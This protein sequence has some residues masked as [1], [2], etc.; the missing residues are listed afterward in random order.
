M[1]GLMDKLFGTQK[2]ASE[3]AKEEIIAPVVPGKLWTHRYFFHKELMMKGFIEKDEIGDGRYRVLDEY[4]NGIVRTTE[5]EYNFRPWLE[6]LLSAGLPSEP[7]LDVFEAGS[8][9]M[10]HCKGYPGHAIPDFSASDQE[11]ADRIRW[12][13]ENSSVNPDPE[14]YNKSKPWIKE[15]L[16]YLRTPRFPAVSRPLMTPELHKEDVGIHV[17]DFAHT[18]LPYRG[19]WDFDP[20][21]WKTAAKRIGEKKFSRLDSPVFFGARTTENVPEK[22]FDDTASLS[23]DSIA[24]AVD[25]IGWDGYRESVSGAWFLGRYNSMATH[26]N[27][28]IGDQGNPDTV[29]KPALEMKDIVPGKRPS[30]PAMYFQRI[31]D[32]RD[33]VSGGRIDVARD[34]HH[35][36]KHCGE[37]DMHFYG[38]KFRYELEHMPLDRFGFLGPVAHKP[39]LFHDWL[40]GNKESEVFA[41]VR[42]I[43]FRI[44]GDYVRNVITLGD[45]LGNRDHRLAYKGTTMFRKDMMNIPLSCVKGLTWELDQ[46]QI[47][48]RIVRLHLSICYEN[49]EV[50]KRQFSI[51]IDKWRDTWL[52]DA[53][54]YAVKHHGMSMGIDPWDMEHFFRLC[55]YGVEDRHGS[56][57]SAKI[58]RDIL[59]GLLMEPDPENAVRMRFHKETRFS[60]F[61]L[62]EKTGYRHLRQEFLRRKQAAEGRAMGHQWE[63]RWEIPLHE[64]RAKYKDLFPTIHEDPKHNYSLMEHYFKNAFSGPLT[65]RPGEF[66]TREYY[67]KS[68]YPEQSTRLF[69]P[70]PGHHNVDEK[71]NTDG[72]NNTLVQ[73]NPTP[74]SLIKDYWRSDERDKYDAKEPRQFLAEGFIRNG[75]ELD[76]RVSIQEY[77]D[78]KL[79][80]LSLPPIYGL[81]SIKALRESPSLRSVSEDEVLKP[82]IMERMND[83]YGEKDRPE[84]CIADLSDLSDLTR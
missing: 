34:M 57:N 16:D 75:E 9:S 70:L 61:L 48:R 47:D 83:S 80:K 2:K 13:L 22:F 66:F 60:V 84:D 32:S 12:L 3:Q 14:E 63:H 43:V 62:A 15:F 55:R 64:V 19:Q 65:L 79:N 28:G 18:Y 46:V 7:E 39:W 74:W 56:T 72:Y 10:K 41:E 37:M 1:F 59:Y 11:M 31:Y 17:V 67:Y 68:K 6:S 26:I 76:N 42:R 21:F 53:I 58:H 29:W 45:L 54:E 77:Y 82:L 8:I 51:V 69:P 30:D 24:D 71:G 52:F 23:V 50:G 20:F 44:V 40:N 38:M 36:L 78:F 4:P 25:E 27:D 5:I 49:G 35:Y 81:K 73:L 33:N